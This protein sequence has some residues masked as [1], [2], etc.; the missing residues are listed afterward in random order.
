MCESLWAFHRT[1]PSPTID[2]FTVR[3]IFCVELY[4]DQD[5]P[6]IGLHNFIPHGKETKTPHKRCGTFS[7]LSNMKE[8]NENAFL[9]RNREKKLKNV[10]PRGPWSSVSGKLNLGLS[11]C[12]C[13]LPPPGTNAMQTRNFGKKKN[14][15]S[16]YKT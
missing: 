1:S 5:S 3:E 6:L 4:Q 8:Y 15:S 13:R 11:G 12:T 14:S 2:S 9:E 7:E 10:G 16:L